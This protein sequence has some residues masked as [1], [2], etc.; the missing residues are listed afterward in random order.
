MGSITQA[1]VAELDYFEAIEE[2]TG[3]GHD[4]LTEAER[5]AYVAA[6]DTSEGSTSI[7]SIAWYARGYARYHLWKRHRPLNVSLEGIVSFTRALHLEPT[8][9][10]A[11]L[12]RVYLLHDAEQYL[13]A[14][15]DLSVLDRSQFLDEQSW[16]LL[17][18]DEIELS[19]RTHLGLLE[20]SGTSDLI[21]RLKC[22][23]AHD[24]ATFPEFPFGPYLL[25]RTIE[26]SPE[27]RLTQTYLDLLR[28]AKKSL[29]G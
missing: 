10:W 7:A 5:G 29:P 20:H 11:L 2:M 19:C 28:E 6:L 17:S 4:R 13:A 3:F 21:Q 25:V 14:L 23:F 1:D 18:A 9:A 12:Y 8:N 15:G 27:L 26:E 16:R 22:G 24:R